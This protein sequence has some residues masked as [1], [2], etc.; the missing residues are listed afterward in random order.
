[1]FGHIRQGPDPLLK[2]NEQ[3]VKIIPALQKKNMA[4]IA[5]A[6]SAIAFKKMPL[7]KNWDAA[8]GSA[9]VLAGQA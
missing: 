3:N 9:G 7:G 4:G 5:F 8:T 1:L 2:L 6:L